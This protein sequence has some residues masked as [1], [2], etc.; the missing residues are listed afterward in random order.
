MYIS[1]TPRL[2]TAS[3]LSLGIGLS[4]FFQSIPAAHAGSSPLLYVPMGNEDNIA[5]VDTHDGKIIRRIAD[6]ENIHGLA[7]VPATGELVA[8]SY[9]E[10]KDEPVK[11]LPKPV[12]VSADEHAAHHAPKNQTRA[13]DGSYGLVSIIDP[14]QG[15]VTRRIEVAA[16]VHHME[17]SPRSDFAVAT[18]P[19]LGGVSIINL[20][21]KKVMKTVLT[22]TMPNYS[23]FSKD[24]TR[25]YVSNA[26]D[27]TISEI[28]TERWIVRRNLI[29]GKG[30]EHMILGPDG[31][32]IYVN[33]VEDGTVFEIDAK[34]GETRRSFSIG[35]EIHGID[36]AD[37][38]GTLYVAGM[39]KNVI[40][41]ID[42]KD[43]TMKTASPGPE[44]YHLFTLKGTGMVYVSSAEDD[45][46]WA[47]DGRTLK[48][49][50]QID[51]GGKG[52]QMVIGR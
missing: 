38:G 39:E 16:P 49:T 41:A 1:M 50:G 42:L 11:A 37:D 27:G 47:L 12:G 20:K 46:I 8:G 5:V 29:A 34:N 4:A 36:L 30:P 26:G 9:S 44:P 24:G 45:T 21:N 33:N 14:D 6:V 25:L 31:R 17:V 18:H 22:G 43:G 28:D 15:T 35:G 52:H 48:R 7:R 13:K 10:Y 32:N 51:L 23:A 3:V 40:A 2:L 19:D